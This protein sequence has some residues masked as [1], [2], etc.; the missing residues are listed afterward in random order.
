MKGSWNAKFEQDEKVAQKY[1]RDVIV[2]MEEFNMHSQRKYEKYFYYR[3]A[4]SVLWYIGVHGKEGC[5]L[6]QFHL[7]IEEL[8]MIT[9]HRADSLLD[10]IRT[11]EATCCRDYY[12]VTIKEKRSSLS[13]G[14]LYLY[15]SED[16]EVITAVA[17]LIIAQINISGI[18]VADK[19]KS[20]VRILD[21]PIYE[22]D[23]IDKDKNIIIWPCMLKRERLICSL[24]DRGFKNIIV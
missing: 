11:V 19:K 2:F 4:D 10:K 6:E 15:G 16:M 5:T 17:S 24:R 14:S 1:I 8:K 20:H 22:I 13:R 3:L 12:Q 18:I 9:E 21:Y 23:E 7:Y